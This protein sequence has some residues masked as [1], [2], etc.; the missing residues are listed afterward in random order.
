V[1]YLNETDYKPRSGWVYLNY[2]KP[3]N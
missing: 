1:L 2:W 3:N